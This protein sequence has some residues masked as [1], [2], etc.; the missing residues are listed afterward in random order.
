MEGGE[1]GRLCCGAHSLTRPPCWAA[2]Q[3]GDNWKIA[4]SDSDHA[5]DVAML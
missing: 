5:E 1:W 2:D 3:D 4:Y